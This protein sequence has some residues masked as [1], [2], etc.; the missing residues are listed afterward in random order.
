MI[1]PIAR[2][3]RKL[4]SECSARKRV[5]PSTYSYQSLEIALDE[6]VRNKLACFINK[7]IWRSFDE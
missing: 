3:N 2:R 6:T 5:K 7:T 4:A 1:K